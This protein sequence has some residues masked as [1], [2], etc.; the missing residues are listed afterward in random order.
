MAEEFVWPLCHVDQK[1]ASMSTLLTLDVRTLPA[2]QRHERI[3]ALLDQLA[4]GQEL[5]LINDHEPRPLRYQI[6]AAQPESFAWDPQQTAVHEWT[7]RIRRLRSSVP[8][9]QMSLP[10]RLPHFSPLLSV[11]KLVK[12]YPQAMPVLARFGLTPQTDDPRSLRDVAQQS[13]VALDEIM[14]ALELAIA[15]ATSTD[16]ERT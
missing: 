3:F 4:I 5:V 7:V 2:P 16:P 8:L 14:A 1:G 10:A 12:R 13:G 9:R 15:G 6:Q 11:A